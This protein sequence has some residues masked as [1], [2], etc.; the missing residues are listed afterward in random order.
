MHM[1]NEHVF[2]DTHAFLW[3]LSEDKG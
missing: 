1:E 3:Y 2:T